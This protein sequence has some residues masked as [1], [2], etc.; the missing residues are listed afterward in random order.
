MIVEPA[1]IGAG[2][3]KLA[4]LRSALERFARTG[5]PIVAFVRTP[6]TRD[7]FLASAAPLIVAAPGDYLNVK[8]LRVELLYARGGLDKLGIVPEF[9]SVGRYKDGPDVLT[10]STMSVPTAEVMNALLDQRFATLRDAV[11]RAR[12]KSP[13]QVRALIDGG[14][15]LAAEARENG[16]ID[17][18]EYSS[19]MEAALARR[20][21]QEKLTK[22]DALLYQRVPAR[23]LGLEGHAR[24]A[25]VAASGEIT[26]G[27]SYDLSEVLK[28]DEFLALMKELREDN[29]IRGVVLR[30]DSPGGDAVASGEMLQAVRELA[31]TKPVVA[32][33][34]D[35]A[36]SG[37]YELAIGAPWIVAY[38]ESLAGSIGIFF[39][40]LNLAGLY[41]KLGLRYEVLT[42]GRHADMDSA[43][44]GL[45]DGE[46][47]RLQQMLAAMYRDFVTEVAKARQ[48][49]YEQIDAVAQG[50]VWTGSDAMPSGLVDQL[51]GLDA[52][53][54]RV[55]QKIGVN[56]AS[57]LKL[58]LHP[59]PPTPMAYWRQQW[60]SV[61]FLGSAPATVLRRAP[62]KIEIR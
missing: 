54:L 31:A 23:S 19:A 24:V 5:K 30:I 28:P 32:S 2:W 9:E 25:V 51:G 50:R 38:P 39:G 6:A 27:G 62:A 1:G 58:E 35:L 3:A 10:R 18:V 57:K 45:D 13:E 46:R 15:Y 11:S 49:S 48:R 12:K 33:I 37:G 20:L 22:L 56:A 21:G 29:G 17:A 59:K 36:A 44:T 52:A 8:G 43:V 40:K 61:P 34:S 53:L 14:P 26:R 42:R 55:A 41:Q 7:Y 47:L 60:E 4:E 16:L